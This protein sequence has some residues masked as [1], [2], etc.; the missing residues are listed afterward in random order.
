MLFTAGSA[1]VRR[2]LMKSFFDVCIKQIFANMD[3]LIRGINVSEVL[4]VGGFGESPYLRDELRRKYES[5]V[6]KVWLLDSSRPSSKAV[7]DGAIIWSYNLSDPQHRGR[8][9]YVG[10]DG[11]ELVAGKWDTIVVKVPGRTFTNHLGQFEGMI[12]A[13]AGDSP[14]YWSKNDNGLYNPGFRSECKVTA[15]LQNLSGALE[16]S[17]GAGGKIYWEL[18]FCLCIRF[19]GVELEAFIEWKENVKQFIHHK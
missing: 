18:E 6:C 10:L 4:L 8:E 16:M 9:F 13:Y 7:A 15:N 17:F 19:G 12:E 11:R 3:E 2:N 14:P 1:G 5:G